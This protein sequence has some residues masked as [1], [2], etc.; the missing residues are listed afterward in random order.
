MSVQALGIGRNALARFS[1]VCEKQLSS[2]AANRDRIAE[3]LR[4]AMGA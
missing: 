1:N 2:M 3:Y 4:E